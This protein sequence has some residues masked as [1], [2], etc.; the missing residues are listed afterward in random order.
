MI[1]PDA[2]VRERIIVDDA[3]AISF[4]GPELRVY[5]TP[6]MLHD[7]EMVCRNLLVPMLEPGQD[8][9]GAT[10]AVTHSGPAVLG[11]AVD[12]EAR[13]VDVSGR[14]V[15]FDVS[16]STQG[17]SVGH[18]RHER[19]VVNMDKLK[20]RVSELRAKIASGS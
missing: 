19:M 2:H 20:A 15:T 5:A 9:V 4:M 3:R 1:E 16:V 6:S 8:S 11:A 17:E 10:A 18:V 13:I 7:V 14:K 12:I